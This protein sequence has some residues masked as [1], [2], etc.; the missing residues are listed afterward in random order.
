MFFV[1]IFD[2]KIH[3]S[4]KWG[5]FSINQSCKNWLFFLDM[6]C[7]VYKVIFMEFLK[8]AKIESEFRIPCQITKLQGP[9]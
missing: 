1:I 8:I 7:K 6:S 2:R 4:W 5:I 3:T 9:K